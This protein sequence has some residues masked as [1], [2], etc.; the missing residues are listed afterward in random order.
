MSNQLTVKDYFH[1]DSVMTQFR[2]VLGEREANAY[3]ASVLIAVA[4][5]DALQKCN[6]ISIITSAMRAATLQLSCDPS[7]GQAYLVPFGNK[8]TLIVGYKGLIHM[9][10]R[11]GKYRFLNV[12]N[13]YEGEYLTEN[14]LTGLHTLNGG[15]QSDKVVGYLLYFQLINGFEKTFYMSVDEIHAHGKRYSKSY[16][17]E[18]SPWKTHTA[19]MERKTPLRLGLSRWGYFD[20]HDQMVMQQIDKSEDEDTIEAEVEIP[21]EFEPEP[22]TAYQEAVK[23][24]SEAQLLMEL[25]Y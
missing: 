25:G 15:K 19:D 22:N 8:C 7:L 14:R 17:R 5:N 1:Q 16:N 2:E 21:A 24:K 9:A 13:I 4:N 3:V 10:F 6:P 11:T 12:A 23:K 18:D 20:P